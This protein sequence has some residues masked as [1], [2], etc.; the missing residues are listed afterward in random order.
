MRSD[1]VDD[2]ALGRRIKAQGFRWR[3]ADATRD[4]RCR[5]YQNAGQVFEGF[6]KNLFAGFGYRL[7]P[8]LVTWVWLVIAFLLP[9]GVL[10][11]RLVGAPVPDVRH[12]PCTDRRNRRACSWGLAYLRFGVPAYLIPLYPVTLLLAL[13]IALRS[14]RLAAQGQSTWKGRTLVQNRVR[15]W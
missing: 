1:A 8:F 11:L 10:L 5:M 4:V 12:R 9:L 2:I 6:S 13:Y 15:W 7:L 14:V 3:L